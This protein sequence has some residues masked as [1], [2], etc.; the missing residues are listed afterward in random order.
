MASIA[1]PPP[2][3]PLP[4]LSLTPSFSSPAE[5]STSYLRAVHRQAQVSLTLAQSAAL[6]AREECEMVEAELRML[7]REREGFEIKRKGLAKDSM[8]V[9]FRSHS[10][11]KV[12]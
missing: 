10:D 6:T 11:T 1:Q 2:F 7:R 9:V 4:L 12:I 8:Y 5:S 3:Q